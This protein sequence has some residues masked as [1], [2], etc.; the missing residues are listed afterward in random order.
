MAIGEI[1]NT[2]TLAPTFDSDF[3]NFISS[4][5]GSTGLWRTSLING[6][7]TL[8]GNG[9]QEY[10]SDGSVGV[11]PFSVQN[12]V[13]DITATPGGN[14]LGLPYNSGV[15]TT[16]NSFNQLYGYFEIDAQLPAGQG[17]WPAF[18]MVPASGAW[19][20]ELDVLEVLGNSP[21]TLYFSTH[22]S[23]APT[24]GTT[25][26]VANTSSGFNLY[27]VM[28]GPQ[29]VDLYINN[30]EVASM[31]TPADMNVPM[32]MLANLAVG[33]Y[34]PG[35]PN[36]TTPFP[37]TMQ[38]AYI[39]AFA[40]P[41]T[42]GGT[43]YD[44][45]PSQ[46]VGPTAIAPVIAAPAGF[47]ATNGAATLMPGV[48]V[49]ANWPGGYFT[50][51]VSDSNGRLNTAATSDVFTTGENTTSLTLTGNLA[52]INAAL[53]TLTYT[54]TVL[55][56]D[57]IWVGAT[58]P[59]GEQGTANVVANDVTSAVPVVPPIVVTPPPSPTPSTTTPVV[60]TLTNLT[61]AA[62]ATH[63]L[64]GISVADSQASGT[65][66]VQVSD[67]TGIVTTAAV[68]GVTS[69]GEGST[70]LTLTG[71]L[72]AINLEL[73]SL[74]Y[75][76]G[77]NAGTEWLW[78]SANG[79]SGGQGVSSVVVTATA[80][81]VIST[82]PPATPPP[83]PPAPV[84]APLPVVTTP[85]SLTLDTG[86]TNTLTGVSVADGQTSDV[87]TVRVSDSI[88]LLAATSVAGVTTQGEGSTAL[89]LTGS[90]AAINQELLGLTYQAGANAGTDW[91][92]VSANDANGRQGVSPTV[93]TVAPL[94]VAPLPVITTPASLTLD[95]GTTNTLT[96][97]S[98][99]GGQ[100]SDVLTVRVSDSIGLLAAASVAGVTTQGEGST[101]L[102]LTGS[103]A[104]INQELLVLTYQAGAN[105]GTDWLCVSANDA[106]GGQG[107]S[108]TVVTVAPLPVAPLPVI[109]TPASLTLVEGATRVL[110]GVS[111]T[112]S[113]ASGTFSVSVSD[114]SGLLSTL[115]IAGV[116]VQGEGSNRLTLT[117][118]LAAINAELASLNY[119]A[120]AA[121]G[122]DWLWISANDANGGQG[123]SPTVVTVSPLPA[124]VLS[125][126]LQG[127]QLTVLTGSSAIGAALQVDNRVLENT[128]TL[129]WYGGT[130]VL[131][132]GDPTAQT[133]TGT[134]EN[135]AGAMFTIEGNGTATVAGGIGS[136]TIVN[137]GTLLKDGG[138]GDTTILAPLVNSGTVDV[139][140]G[141][142]SLEQTV[143]GNGT[144]LLHGLSTLD[145]AGVV[146]TGGTIN[147]LSPTA[148]LEVETTGAF[149]ATILGFAQGN[150]IDAA[151]ISQGAATL[152][153]F[154]QAGNGGTLSISDGT[155][156]AQFALIGSYTT[157]AFHIASDNHGGTSIML[158]P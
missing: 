39:K 98:V 16:E 138:L 77:A 95:T 65:F 61:L 137:A 9:E 14:A 84:V 81:S 36:G 133:H 27:G 71:T 80:S 6:A 90:L 92:W 85:A 5:D 78:V 119:Q 139:A 150:T 4:P 10:Y 47:Q 2:T 30:V 75:Q 86:T 132:G 3:K 142:L 54:G 26:S 22:S 8:G 125:D 134:L 29:T 24:N 148:T 145:F 17:L 42:T 102:T 74:T 67:S 23:V 44:T 52:P 131:G 55:G 152:L 21:S 20:P 153:N 31:P 45:L 89:T 136:G 122:T 120:S 147:F 144:F 91:L 15:I 116:T 108:P 83:V 143:S 64:A 118:G 109:T 53:A 66:T 37:A 35:N 11:D 19:P 129:A 113:Q 13:L 135:A 51:M 157:A 94:P 73:A 149:G 34:W 110:S 38:I 155:H 82:P 104:A 124:A 158:Q 40:Y 56:N 48:S 93:V 62:G 60:T 28:W 101:T 127:P 59:Q 106:N 43:V 7:R 121:A 88:G 97:V 128:G 107:V 141:T 50:V 114:T 115:P 58:N 123:V 68:S 100:T 103:L 33:G 146:G 69:Q 1:I 154:T 96:G 32:Y 99:A 130:I 70:T 12:G 18:W 63:A 57:W 79:A 111:V 41:G 140:A 87:L 25:L 112:D 151:S 117:G 105:A 126:V 76:A 46:N 72:A 156:S 49:A